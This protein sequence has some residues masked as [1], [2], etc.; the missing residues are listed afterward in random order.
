MRLNKV[1]KAV[2]DI[3]KAMA[4]EPKEIPQT[5]LIAA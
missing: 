4:Q 5:L 2:D 3:L 1:F